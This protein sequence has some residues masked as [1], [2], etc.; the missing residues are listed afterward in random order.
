[1][2]ELKASEL[3]L[4]SNSDSKLDKGDHIIDAKPSATIATTQIHPD[5]PEDPKEGECLFHSKMWVKGSS[6]HFIIDNGSQN[7]TFK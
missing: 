2:E 4:D 5:D 7:I 3:Y 6:L 1:M